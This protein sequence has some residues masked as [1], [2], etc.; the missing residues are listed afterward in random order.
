MVGVTRRG[1]ASF[2][3]L[4]S[5]TNGEFVPPKASREL[6]KARAL[7][8]ERAGDHA[9]RL[10]MD[11]RA[12]LATAC[13]AATGLVALNEAFAGENPGG[14]FRVAPTAALDVDEAMAALGGREFIF[15]VQTHYVDPSG[16]WRRNPFS[17]WNITL[18]VFP[19][20]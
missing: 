8:F 11:R 14:A 20:A 18:R 5:A 13:G 10:G 19:Q 1:P 7:A 6:A 12:F 3:K 4:D 15:D 9:R 16:P 2:I 17:P